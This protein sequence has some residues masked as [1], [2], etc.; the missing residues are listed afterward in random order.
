MPHGHPD[1]FGQSVWPKYGEP[2]YINHVIALEPGEEESHVLTG[3]GV[4][5]AV[6]LIFSPSS[7]WPGGRIEVYIDGSY[8]GEVYP[9]AW[10][11]ALGTGQAR[12]I[13]DVDLYGVDNAQSRAVLTR[14]VPFSSSITFI[15]K[16]SVG[17]GADT[18]SFYIGGIFYLIA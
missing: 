17:A 14:E 15:S 16:N 8:Y 11:T 4:L 7:N 9:Y 10:F 6:R 18:V 13:F 2:S 3:P 12:Q 5:F 1:W